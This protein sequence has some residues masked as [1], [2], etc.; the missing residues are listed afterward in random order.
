MLYKVELPVAVRQAVFR[1]AWR[2][3]GPGGATRDGVYVVGS[4]GLD[5]LL[6]R[7]AVAGEPLISAVDFLA[8]DAY[9]PPPAIVQAVCDLLERPSGRTTPNASA[10]ETDWLAAAV[11]VSCSARHSCATFADTTARPGIS[12]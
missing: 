4:E 1:A 11:I 2:G 12:G 7:L 8:S 9:A 10:C 6:E 3:W 5:T